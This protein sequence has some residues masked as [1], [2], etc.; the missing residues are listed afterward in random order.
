M[1]DFDFV[2]YNG[3]YEFLHGSLSASTSPT[4][5][6]IFFDSYCQSMKLLFDKYSKN[7]K[8]ESPFRLTCMIGKVD[9]LLL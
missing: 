1:R 7:D 4:K 9:S 2:V 6:D 8:L 5:D 3:Y